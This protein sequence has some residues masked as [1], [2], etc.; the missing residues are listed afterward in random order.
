MKIL[1]IGERYSSNLGDPIICE[2]V[3]WLIK[4]EIPNVKISFLDL[5]AREDYGYELSNK[6]L[7]NSGRISSL[8]KKLSISLTKL[9]VDT[10][11]IKFKRIHK[12]KIR[13]FDDF[14]KDNN[15]I[16]LAIF[17]GGQMF[18]DTFI[19]PIATVVKYLNIKN[20]PVLFNACGYGE[21]TSRKM[22]NILGKTLRCENVSLISSRDDVNS[23]NLLLADKHKKVIKTYDP[24]LWTSEVYKVEKQESGIIGLG[25]MFAHNMKYKEMLEFWTKIISELETRNTKWKL[26]CNGPVK[27]YEFAKHI[28]RNMKYKEDDIA[29]YVVQPPKRPEELVNIIS[30]FSG[31]IS[32][33]LHSHI[34]AYALDIPGI[35]VL[36]D[37]KVQ[38]FYDSIEYSNSCVRID[39]NINVILDKVQKMGKVSYNDKLKESQQLHL[40]NLLIENININTSKKRKLN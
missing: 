27:D 18:K 19:F 40:L 5:S 24:A 1:I 8:K 34:V 36:W 26:F 13:Y 14:F 39:E 17:A 9:G 29:K 4:R 30:N 3:E 31:I 10:E 21:I 25:V 32:F 2:S 37:K 33:R 6:K 20:I 23:I 35:G 12:N 16:D 15:D 11:Y 22:S 38:Y 7:V 28:L